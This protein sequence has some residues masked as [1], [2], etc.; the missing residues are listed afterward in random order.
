MHRLG[1]CCSVKKRLTGRGIRPSEKKM[2]LGKGDKYAMCR[3]RITKKLRTKIKYA[4]SMEK[5]EANEHLMTVEK[6]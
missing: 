1:E 5:N 2:I 4:I 3:F 6:F